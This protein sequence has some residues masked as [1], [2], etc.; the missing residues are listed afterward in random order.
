MTRRLLI[1]AATLAAVL[2]TAA[3]AR[4]DWIWPVRGEV[5][6]PYR[7]GDD[8]YAAGQHRGIDIAA[9]PGTPV[10]AA[11]GGEIR[12]SGTAG[13]SGLTVSIRTD[14]GV[15]DTSY[16]HLSTTAVRT[17]ERVAAG[18]RIGAV[19]T[20]GVRSAERPHLHFGVRE[21]GSRHAYHDPLAFLPPPAVAPERPRT[22]PAPSPA[23]VPVVPAPATE[24]VREP[25]SRGAPGRVPAPRPVPAFR[26]AP[27]PRGAPVRLPAPHSAPRRAPVPRG[28]PR[29]VPGPHGAP[30]AIPVPRGAPRRAPA[31]RRV[32]ARPRTADRAGHRAPL[33]GLAPRTAAAADRSARPLGAGGGPDAGWVVACLGLLAA[34]AL[35]GLS[36]DGRRATRQGRRRITALVS[37]RLGG[38]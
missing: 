33:S 13:S 11:A 26:P 31:G 12:F 20:T 34:S 32:P 8:P 15:Y 35:L 5:I 9:D 6:T 10:V 23:P 37:P 28:A 19:G 21:A 3:P 25:V 29:P 16:L 1:P 30:R 22:T 4:A 36:E 14:D 18:Q 7:N 27:V 24:P 38:R 2:L 17:G